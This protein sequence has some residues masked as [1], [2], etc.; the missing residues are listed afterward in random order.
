MLSL[1]RYFLK[2]GG[3]LILLGSLVGAYGG[4]K[5]HTYFTSPPPT[6]P[7]TVQFLRAVVIPHIFLALGMGLFVFGLILA[8]KGIHFN[9]KHR[10]S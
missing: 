3:F 9:V 6:D 7:T 4:L 8:G 10:H 1:T 5:L 2:T